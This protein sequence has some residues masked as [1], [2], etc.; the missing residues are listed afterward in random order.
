[1]LGLYWSSSHHNLHQTIYRGNANKT[2][3][4]KYFVNSPQKKQ[5]NDI[6]ISTGLN[7]LDW[8]EIITAYI[9][10]PTGYEQQQQSNN[11]CIL[12]K[13]FRILFPEDPRSFQDWNELFQN[14]TAVHFASSQTFKIENI[15]NHNRVMHSRSKNHDFNQSEPSLSMNLDQ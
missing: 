11:N 4:I 7:I 9:Y 14:S 12:S 5:I 6:T 2:I 3:M 13:H 1:M 10:N 15:G 8:K